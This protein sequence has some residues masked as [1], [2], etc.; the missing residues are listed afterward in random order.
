MLKIGLQEENQCSQSY[1][2]DT[3]APYVHEI[4]KDF[5]NLF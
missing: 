2:V 3:M 5:T 4:K 1:S